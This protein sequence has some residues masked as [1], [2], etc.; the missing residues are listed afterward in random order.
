MWVFITLR[1]QTLQYIPIRNIL[2]FSLSYIVLHCSN[3]YYRICSI[4]IYCN[5]VS[6]LIQTHRHRHIHIYTYIQTNKHTHLWSY[7]MSTFLSI[8][9][10]SSKPVDNLVITKLISRNKTRMSTNLLHLNHHSTR[11]TS[12]YNTRLL[13]QWRS[14]SPATSLG[15]YSICFFSCNIINVGDPNYETSTHINYLI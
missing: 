1:Q 2:M 10:N 5:I 15:I 13:D 8:N 4:S 9:F 14:H 3:K 12:E 6:S 11:D 7:Q